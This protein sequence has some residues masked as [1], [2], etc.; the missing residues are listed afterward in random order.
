MTTGIYQVQIVKKARKVLE[1]LPGNLKIRIMAVIDGLAQDPT[2]VGCV[3]LSGYDN[4][5]RI[6]GDWCIAYAIEADIL[7]VLVL[8]ISPRGSVYRNL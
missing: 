1:K 8:K 6:R 7:I 4:L 5:Y 2:P 3:K